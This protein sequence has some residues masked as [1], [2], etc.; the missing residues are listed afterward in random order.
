MSHA[1]TCLHNQLSP[2]RDLNSVEMARAAYPT[3]ILLIIECISR[4]RP[5]FPPY[6][7]ITE[8]LAWGSDFPKLEW[9]IVRDADEVLIPGSGGQSICHWLRRRCLGP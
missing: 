7:R 4:E 6:V 9:P 2:S 8:K 1:N 3:Q 5:D